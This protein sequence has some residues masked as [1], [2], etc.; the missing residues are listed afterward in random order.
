MPKR[1]H[2]PPNGPVQAANYVIKIFLLIIGISILG[3]FAFEIILGIKPT[4]IECLAIITLVIISIW[5][6]ERKQP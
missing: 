5:L 4:V 6:K 1:R 2:S 3:G